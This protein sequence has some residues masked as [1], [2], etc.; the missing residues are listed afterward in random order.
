MKTN[1]YNSELRSIAKNAGFS[2]LGILF[3]NVM[4]FLNNAVITRVLGADSYGLFVLATNIFTFIAIIPQFGFGNT[5]VRYVSYYRGKGEEAKVKG[6]I[7]FGFKLLLLLSLI[8]LVISFFISPLISENIFKRPGL[9]P[10]LKIILLSLPFAVIAG[11]F[12]SALN[13]LKLIK[14][15]VIG[16]NIL[17]PLI[18]FLFISIVFYAGYRLSGLIWIMVAMGVI[19]VILSWYFLNKG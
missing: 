19:S 13:G 15:Q 11:V 16:G 6:T 4:A 18:F 7:M 17:N 8:V 12:Y 9:T 5:I 1:E 3:M 10:L 14:Y 2:A